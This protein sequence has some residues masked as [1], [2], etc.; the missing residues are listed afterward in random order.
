VFPRV[1]TVYSRNFDVSRRSRRKRVIRKKC[2]Y[3]PRYLIN[4]CHFWPCKIMPAYH[5]FQASFRHHFL[6]SFCKAI[7]EKCRELFS[8]NMCIYIYIY[9][10]IYIPHVYYQSMNIKLYSLASI[11]KEKTKSYP[12]PKESNHVQGERH[13]YAREI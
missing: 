2:I 9:I 1:Y 12:T 3:L 6:H 5:S 4:Q 13:S 10:Y 11:T 7:S 8:L